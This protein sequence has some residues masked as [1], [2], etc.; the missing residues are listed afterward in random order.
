LLRLEQQGRR[1]QRDQVFIGRLDGQLVALDRRTASGG[2]IQ[3]ERWEENF[4]ITAAPL[5]VE[6]L[7]RRAPGAKAV[8]SS[9]VS[10]AATAARGSVFKAY[11]AKDGA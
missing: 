9:S 11:D 3:A 10:P 6:G 8:W 5:Y 2:S 4:S 7:S 1:G